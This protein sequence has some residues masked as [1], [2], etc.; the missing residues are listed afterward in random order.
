MIQTKKNNQIKI[1]QVIEEIIAHHNHDPE[2]ILEI[3]QDFLVRKIDLS[4]Q[5][6]AALAEN[7]RIPPRSVYGVATFYSM[8]SL[9][10]QTRGI[11]RVCNGPVCWMHGSMEIKKSH[12]QQL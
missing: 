10:K 1:N 3:L 4:K 7:L 6:I 5:N 9:G 2:A 12:L 8:L 11:I